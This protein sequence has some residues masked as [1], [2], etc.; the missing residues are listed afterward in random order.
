MPTLKELEKKYEPAV[1]SRNYQDE[2]ES[3]LSAI[4]NELD[5]VTMIVIQGATPSFDDGDPCTHW[6]NTVVNGCGEA[7]NTEEYVFE[8]ECLQARLPKDHPDYK[9]STYP[10]KEEERITAEEYEEAVD[11]LKEAYPYLAEHDLVG[12]IWGEGKDE[13]SLQWERAQTLLERM[14]DVFEGYYG[15]N[16]QVIAVRDESERGYS[17]EHQDYYLGY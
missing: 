14:S 6:Q 7:S 15:T 12:Y 1:S 3:A 17:L 5:L 16:W 8:L 13:K 11:E 10:V 2:I 9:E 4:F